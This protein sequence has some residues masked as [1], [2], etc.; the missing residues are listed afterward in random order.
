MLFIKE[1]I[2]FVNIDE[3]RFGTNLLLAGMW[4][5][6]FAISYTRFGYNP[7]A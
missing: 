6:S 7:F 4:A 2:G 3:C 5:A 1:F